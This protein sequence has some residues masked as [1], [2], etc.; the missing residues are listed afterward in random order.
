MC[1]VAAARH[2]EDGLRHDGPELVDG[3]EPAEGGSETP[4]GGHD[5][6][7]EAQTADADAEV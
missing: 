4:G 6:V 3:D 1:G 7:P 5:R 2:A